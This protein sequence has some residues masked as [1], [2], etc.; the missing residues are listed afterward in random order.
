M[1]KQ[2]G[3]IGSTED[4]KYSTELEKI[5]REIGKEIALSGNILVFGA[6]KDFNSIPTI[7]A[8]EARKNN[9]LTIGVT[10]GTKKE[11]N[12]FCKDSA[13]VV[14]Y[15]GLERGGGRE[16]VLINSC[17]V[18]IAISG[19]SGTLNEMTIAYQLNIPIIAIEGT[20]GWADK[21]ANQ[22][23][24]NRKRFKVVGVKNVKDA[25]DKILI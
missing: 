12:I 1:K 4:L 22:F 25:M 7:A 17:D 18:V 24:D 23:F 20:G 15:S 9:G 10:Y 16:F 14:V 21:M 11:K 13:D 19:G 8:L 6:E 3:V 2:I 5:A